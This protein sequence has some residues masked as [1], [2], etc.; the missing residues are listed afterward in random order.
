MSVEAFLAR[1]YCDSALRKA[2]LERPVETARVAGLSPEEAAALEH[3]DRD[4]LALAAASFEG[5]RRNR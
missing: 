1:L 2:F 3:I 4:G 5:K